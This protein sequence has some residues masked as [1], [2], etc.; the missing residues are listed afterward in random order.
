MIL[1]QRCKVNMSSIHHEK[2][3]ASKDVW[4]NQQVEELLLT[5]SPMQNNFL[6]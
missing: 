2:Q 1:V 3:P 6:S 4:N 5:W